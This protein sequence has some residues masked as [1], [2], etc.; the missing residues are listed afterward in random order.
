MNPET[1]IVA[2]VRLA[3]PRHVRLFRNNVGMAWTRDGT[4]V[5]YGLCPGSADLIGWTVR[6]G[7][8]VFTAVEVKTP[9]GVVSPEQRVFLDAVRD[10][11]GIALV[12][13]GA[14]D[15]EGL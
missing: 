9:R 2:A 6:D 7:V 4:P 5:R 8:A 11:G 15:V 1:P 13:R 14:G 3:A 12:A 10:A